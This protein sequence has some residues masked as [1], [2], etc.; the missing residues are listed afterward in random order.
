LVFFDADSTLLVFYPFDGVSTMAEKLLP[1]TVIY[2]FFGILH[3]DMHACTD[4]SGTFMAVPKSILPAISF[5]ITWNLNS[6]LSCSK[7]HLFA[8]L[9]EFLHLF[10]SRAA[11]LY[12]YLT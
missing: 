8:V 4:Y 9:S 3:S 11:L 2:T 5:A 1:R 12:T 6:C 7:C 10:Y